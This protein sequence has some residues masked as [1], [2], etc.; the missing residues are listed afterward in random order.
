MKCS[1]INYYFHSVPTTYLRIYFVLRISSII[2][3]SLIPVSSIMV[4]VVFNLLSIVV[5]LKKYAVYNIL[6]LSML[7][8]L[9][10]NITACLWPVWYGMVCNLGFVLCFQIYRVYQ[11][12]VW[13]TVWIL[14]SK[15]CDFE[16]NF[17]MNI[18]K[19]FLEYPNFETK[20][21]KSRII[22]KK[23]KKQNMVFHVIKSIIVVY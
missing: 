16:N 1:L 23:I 8:D 22:L 10:M 2:L 12:Y 20:V 17:F 4:V 5:Y 6:C 7:V 3:F 21:L 15:Q 13:L 18:K 9:H 19:L 11:I 14:W